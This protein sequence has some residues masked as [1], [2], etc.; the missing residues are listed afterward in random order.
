MPHSPEV[1]ISIV[2][3]K[4][5]SDKSLSVP[6][7]GALNGDRAS[8][9]HAASQASQEQLAQ[10]KREISELEQQVMKGTESVPNLP[11]TASAVL[12]LYLTF[13]ALQEG[14]I[15]HVLN[16]HG[17]WFLTFVQFLC[18]TIF[19]IVQHKF[20]EKRRAPLAYYCILAF[21]QVRVSITTPSHEHRDILIGV[22]APS[23]MPCIAGG[24]GWPIKRGRPVSAVPDPHPLQVCKADPHRPHRSPSCA[25]L[26]PLPCPLAHDGKKLHANSVPLHSLITR[27]A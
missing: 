4:D 3:V 15:K 19:S 8:A 22:A 13:G 26:R 5:E 12:T 10:M 1:Q 25:A 24:D 17:G 2:T 27:H 7:V 14:I 21:L 20:S 9:L 16:G 18:Y 11:L 23:Q 6:N